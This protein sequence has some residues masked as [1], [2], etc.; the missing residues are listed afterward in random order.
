MTNLKM[1]LVGFVSILSL[2]S[3]CSAG[4]NALAIQAQRHY[5]LDFSYATHVEYRGATFS[6][7]Q[8]LAGKKRLLACIN[9]EIGRAHV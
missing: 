5:K 6:F 4:T 8:P 2:L 7:M 9:D 3:A 1:K